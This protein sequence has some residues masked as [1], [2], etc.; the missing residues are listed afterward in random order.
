MVSQSKYLRRRQ[1]Q[2]S[3]P[4]VVRSSQAEGSEISASPKR[5]PLDV[6]ITLAVRGRPSPFP[7]DPKFKWKGDFEGT[8]KAGDKQILLWALEDCAERGVPIP[9]WAGKALRRI[10]FHGVARGE[11]ASWED[12][13]GPIRV[14][15]QRT[16]RDLQHMADVWKRVRELKE[17]DGRTIDDLLF[18]DIRK[19]FGMPPRTLARITEGTE[20]NDRA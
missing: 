7:V 4:A 11:F 16:I 15:Q 9:E 20:E 5:D 2:K 14:M 8:F 1:A 13:F 10:M 19:E 3:G 12:A 18:E 6:L 17:R